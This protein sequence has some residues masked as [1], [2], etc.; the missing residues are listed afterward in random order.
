M[1]KVIDTLTARWD[2]AAQA[3]ADIPDSAWWIGVNLCALAEQVERIADAAEKAIGFWQQQQILALRTTAAI[4]AGG[5]DA[6]M[7]DLLTRL[8]DIGEKAQ[9]GDEGGATEAFYDLLGMPKPEPKPEEPP[10][11]PT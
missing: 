3:G 5:P 2:D 1:G 7:S 4:Q 9:A 11:D 10:D 8:A 6:V